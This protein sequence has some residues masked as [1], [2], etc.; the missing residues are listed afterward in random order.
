MKPVP[1]VL[2][3][4]VQPVVPPGVPLAEPQTRAAPGLSMTATDLGV[5][6]VRG[7]HRVLV[8]WCNVKQADES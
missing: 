7:G 8:P 4:W 3:R 5:S 6:M 1:L 2:V